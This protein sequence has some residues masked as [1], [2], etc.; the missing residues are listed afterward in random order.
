MAQT[1][2]EIQKQIEQLQR[3]ADLLRESEIKGV[4]ERIKV[5]IAHY[6]LTA[7]QLGFA[8][9]MTPAAKQMSLSNADDAKSTEK[10]KRN[11][12]SNGKRKPR[13]SDGLGNEWGGMGPRPRW[14]R[15]AL[16]A[17]RDIKEFRIGYRAKP[18]Q[19]L[20][21]PD[22]ATGAKA[23]MAGA[24]APA[25]ASRASPKVHYA[26]DAGHT[27]SG[28]GPRPGWLKSA[29]EAGKKLSDFAR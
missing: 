1:Y 20:A 29:I 19:H 6:G 28:M 9:A 2:A 13:F 16:D 21:Q 5:A 14:L 8:R 3:Q 4:V 24:T 15:E 26:D 17:G 22:V 27:W 25:T 12:K 18:K 10:G 7:D 11:G 23:T